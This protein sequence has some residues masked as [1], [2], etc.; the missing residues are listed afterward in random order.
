M[1]S[2]TTIADVARASGVSPSTVSRALAGS[3]L[4]SGET[5]A[6]VLAAA[7]EIGYIPNRN[8]RA[9]STGD[10]GVLGLIV[11]DL[12]N[13]FFPPMVRAAQHAAEEHDMSVYVA[14]SDNE[15]RRELTLASRM[16]EQA[17]GL[18][19]ASPRLAEAALRR[20][21]RQISCV[22]INRDIKEI[23]RIL[24][25]AGPTLFAA[26]LKQLQA[27]GSTSILYVGGPHLSWSE[28]ERRAAVTRI[29]EQSNIPLTVVHCEQGTYSE[30]RQ[31]VA[32]TTI[33]AGSIVVGY[34]DVI[35]HGLFDEMTHRGLKVPG[36]VFLIGCDGVLPVQTSPGIPTVQL[37]P[38]QAGAQAVG[39]LLHPDPVECRTIPGTLRTPD[40]PSTPQE[41]SHADRR[42]DVPDRTD[43]ELAAPDR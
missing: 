25:P 14:D 3:R 19:L 10:T 24:L 2:K 34:D 26:I 43:T 36:D 29:A 8:A 18:I 13:P 21:N 40:N 41:A 28:T 33:T 15:P 11:P 12:A 7:E 23:P 16:R 31:T 5:I 35:A 27:G 32:N 9:L 30:A 4:I 38:A 37:D 22:L 6:K 39:M 1:A 17:E 20:L 42:V